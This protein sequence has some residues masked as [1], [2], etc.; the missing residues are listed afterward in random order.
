[1]SSAT[2]RSVL[3]FRGDSEAGTR[4]G[5]SSTQ[6]R[7]IFKTRSYGA[8]RMRQKLLVVATGGLVKVITPLMLM[9]F[10]S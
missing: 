10:V 2:S 1:M 8:E 7:S 5:W 4:C 3:E 6:P 9:V